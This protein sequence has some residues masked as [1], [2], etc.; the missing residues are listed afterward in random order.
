MPRWGHGYFDWRLYP[1]LAGT[2]KSSGYATAAAGKWQVNHFRVEP[3][4]MAKH[5]FDSYAMWTGWEEG[6]E[7]SAERYW[8]PYIHTAEGS[9]TY[10]GRFGADIFVESTDL[11]FELGSD[12]AAVGFRLGV[13]FHDA[14][15]IAVFEVVDDVLEVRQTLLVAPGQQ[16]FVGIVCFDGFTE[17]GRINVGGPGG[18]LIDDVQMWQAPLGACCIDGTCFQLTQTGCNSQG[19]T[20]QGDDI[21]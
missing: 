21:P 11:L 16:I 5:G 15:E 19:G 13:V 9:R 10:E 6:V 8:D 3:E 20:Y 14:A 7:A 17:I 12:I 1:S 2:L 18:E 4:A